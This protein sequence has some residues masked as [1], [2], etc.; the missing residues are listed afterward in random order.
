MMHFRSSILLSFVLLFTACRTYSDEQKNQF[1]K[2][3]VAYAKKHHMHFTS[4]ETGLCIELLKQG[5]G[6][7]SIQRGSIVTIHYK[8]TLANGQLVDQSPE[9]KPLTAKIK[10]LIGGFQLGLMG[11]KK[12]S[13]IKL[14]VP[15]HLGYGSDATS[16][17]PANSLLIFDIEVIDFK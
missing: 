12:G 9:G 8:G 13:H 4:D 5:E 6:S 7:E 14:V 11:Q 15:P 10:G 2:A 16:K 3:S 1:S 17:V